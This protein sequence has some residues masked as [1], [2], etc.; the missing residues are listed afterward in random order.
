[1]K[2][3]HLSEHFA[4]PLRETFG[5]YKD[6]WLCYPNLQSH[7]IGLNVLTFNDWME[8]KHG[9]DI[10]KHGSLSNFIREKFG[11]EAENL[12]RELIQGFYVMTDSRVKYEKGLLGE[13]F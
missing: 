11:Q 7:K 4:K 1:M 10:E 12:V 3:E 8:E 5:G 13:M 9:Y 6:N 2:R